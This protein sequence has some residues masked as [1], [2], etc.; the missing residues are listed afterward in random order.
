MR[1]IPGSRFLWLFASALVTF[2]QTPLS[3]IPAPRLDAPPPLPSDLPIATPPTVTGP[4]AP[5]ANPQSNP[6][7]PFQRFNNSGLQRI[8]VVQQGK[9][10]PT[11]P[12]Y[13]GPEVLAWA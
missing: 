7:L 8:P 4:P 11:T 10:V 3:P 2:A 9:P 1:K 12:P 5:L 6:R 13:S